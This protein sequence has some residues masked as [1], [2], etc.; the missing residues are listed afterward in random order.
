MAE[1]LIE[2]TGTV[3]GFTYQPHTY[4][5]NNAGKLVAYTPVGGDRKVFTKP[6]AFSKARR[7]FKKVKS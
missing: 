2:T 5:L 3:D 6:L 7:K 1:V 4:E